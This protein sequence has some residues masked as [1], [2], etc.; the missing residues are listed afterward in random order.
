[1]IYI[2]Q[3]ILQENNAENIL[4]KTKM[5]VKDIIDII[6]FYNVILT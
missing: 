5:D 1:M 2:A 6:I 3:E 4:A